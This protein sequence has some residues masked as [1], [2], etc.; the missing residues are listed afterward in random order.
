MKSKFC[1][2]ASREMYEDYFMQRGNGGPIFI[3]TRG[4]RGHG[5]G[6]ILSGFFRTAFP[7]LKRG[8]AIFGKH[9]LRTGA[10][11]ANDVADGEKFVESSKKRFKETI[12]E[13]VPGLIDQSG[14]GKRRRR[15][16]RQKNKKNRRA[17]K[18]NSTK[19]HT[20]PKKK[21]KKR[22]INRSANRFNRNIF[23]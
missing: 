15:R 4:Q 5:L 3:G 12:N 21:N 9:A 2:D 23:Q 8:L 11:I 16:S 17:K 10:R 13:V 6:S 7:L 22:R 20:I 18:H 19:K 14:S 1:C